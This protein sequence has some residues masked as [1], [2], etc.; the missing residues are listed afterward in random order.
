MAGNAIYKKESNLFTSEYVDEYHVDV[1][2]LD[3]EDIATALAEIA[4]SG[5]IQLA[6]AASPEDGS[7][8]Y[9]RLPGGSWRKL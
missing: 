5:R 8:L 3:D 4:A 2:S 6:L 7:A 9:R 1:T